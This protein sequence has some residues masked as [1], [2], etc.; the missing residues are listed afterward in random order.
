MPATPSDI[1]LYTSDG[2]QIFSPSNPA[3]AAALKA[4]HVNARRLDESEREM[5]YDSGDDAQV[6]LDE[7]FAITSLVNPPAFGIE[8]E[9]SLGLGTRV[10]ITPKVPCYNVVDDRKN[11]RLTGRVRGYSA[12]YGRDRYAV[13]ILCGYTYTAVA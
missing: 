6:V 7:A 2:V 1:A 5:F 12:L 9:E 10:P 8:V 13:E 3:T 11:L 4:T